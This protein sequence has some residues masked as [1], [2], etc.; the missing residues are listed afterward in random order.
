MKKYGF[1]KAFDSI[2]WNFLAMVLE[3]F[4]FGPWIWKWIKMFY[5]N[6][7]SSVINSGPALELF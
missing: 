1:K 4:N 3:A 6:I 7:S 2:D 5:T